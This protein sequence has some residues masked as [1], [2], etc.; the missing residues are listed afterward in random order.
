MNE[1]ENEIIHENQ[2]SFMKIMKIFILPMAIILPIN[3]S[4]IWL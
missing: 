3:I 4:Q 1:N 2:P